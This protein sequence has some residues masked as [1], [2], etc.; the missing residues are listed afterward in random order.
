MAWVV[1]ARVCDVACGEGYV[2]RFLARAGAARSGRP[3]TAVG[4]DVAVTNP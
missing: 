2:S 3:A 4:T 1:G